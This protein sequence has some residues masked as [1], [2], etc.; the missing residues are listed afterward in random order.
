MDRCTTEDAGDS[1][2]SEARLF[3][4]AIL[5]RPTPQAAR[6]EIKARIRRAELEKLA[7]LSDRHAQELRNLQA[8]ERDARRSRELLQWAAQIST[9]AQEKLR[10][11]RQIEEQQR[12]AWHA[13]EQFTEAERSV[14]EWNETDHPRA[15]MG[16]SDGGQWVPKGGGGGGGGG[17][18]SSGR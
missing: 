1:P 4:Q 9:E 18:S 15:P 6:P 5:G 13:V 2:P 17:G 11:I 7:P 14:A 10:A 3:A 8:A 12:R 16:T